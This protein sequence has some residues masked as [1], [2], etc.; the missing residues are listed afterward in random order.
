MKTKCKNL[1]QWNISKATLW[2]YNRGISISPPIS[3]LEQHSDCTIGTPKS[4]LRSDNPQWASRYWKG[5][6]SLN[7]NRKGL[8]TSPPV[9][10]HSI[11]RNIT[12]QH[13]QMM[14]QFLWEVTPLTSL[15]WGVAFPATAA[16]GYPG[17]KQLAWLRR[18]SIFIP[19]LKSVRGHN[20]HWYKPG[21]TSP[22]LCPVIIWAA[23]APLSTGRSGSRGEG[24][25]LSKVALR[26]GEWERVVLAPLT[27]QQSV[28]FK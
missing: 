20:L 25:F 1:S 8:L 13:P 26:Q 14:K 10:L 2:L 28:R 19:C 11:P 7:I 5:S 22:L 16:L 27:G 12:P 3:L 4:F 17:K 18:F 6:L 21:H 23:P 9:Q 24:R 15:R